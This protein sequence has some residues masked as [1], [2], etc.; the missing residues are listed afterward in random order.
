MRARNLFT[1]SVHELCKTRCVTAN[2]YRHS[3][4]NVGL[5]KNRSERGIND[6]IVQPLPERES[7][8]S[9][10]GTHQRLASTMAKYSTAAPNRVMNVVRNFG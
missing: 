4:K 5:V 10:T 9:P 6:L 1:I 3:A 8:V 2:D 7:G